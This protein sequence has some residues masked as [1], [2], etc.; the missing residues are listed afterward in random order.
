MRRVLT[1]LALATMLVLLTA[2]AALAAKPVHE[3]F[4]IDE[5][6]SE[7]LCGVAVTTHL[8]IKGN[9]LHFEDRTIDVSQIRVTFTN[10]GGEWLELFATG[11]AFVTSELDGDIETVTIRQAG[12]QERLRSAEGITPAFD[13]GQITF[14]VTWDLNDL[15][16][17]EDDVFLG[18]EIL[19]V[20]GPHPEAES[21]F[22]LFCEVV[23]DVLG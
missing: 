20:H 15:E 17:P 2:Q 16:D 18:F 9:V 6:F 4:R 21:G 12:V 13:R 14:Q 1:P 10:A 3:K 23:Q 22:E 19:S 8:E 5:T 11:P 7:T